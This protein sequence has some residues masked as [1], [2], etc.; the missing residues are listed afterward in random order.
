MI[1]LAA[2]EMHFRSSTYMRF[3]YL[4]NNYHTQSLGLSLGYKYTTASGFGL[5]ALLES[6]S[7]KEK[8]TLPKRYYWDSDE[9]SANLKTYANLTIGAS[10]SI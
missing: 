2:A 7:W 10:Y 4:G 9:S 1:G 8:K 5:H 3:N 6:T